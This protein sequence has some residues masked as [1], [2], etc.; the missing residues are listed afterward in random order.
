[1]SRVPLKRVSVEMILV[2][3]KSIKGKQKDLATLVT[4][5]VI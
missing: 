5:V 4:D 3:C 2:S 1:M